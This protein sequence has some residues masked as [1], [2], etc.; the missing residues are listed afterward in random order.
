MPRATTETEALYASVTKGMKEMA[1]FAKVNQE[2]HVS[3][4]GLSIGVVE[5]QHFQKK[6]KALKL[7]FF[8]I[9][10]IV[11]YVFQHNFQSF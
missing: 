6:S 8:Y 1:L 7:F 2:L 10:E 11:L 3:S 4:C 5:L 9:C